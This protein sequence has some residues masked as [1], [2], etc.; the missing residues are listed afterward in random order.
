[1]EGPSSLASDLA[2]AFEAASVGV[3][4]GVSADSFG[5]ASGGAPGVALMDTSEA[6]CVGIRAVAGER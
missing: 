1:M 5:A 3:P 2:F 6:A 4:E